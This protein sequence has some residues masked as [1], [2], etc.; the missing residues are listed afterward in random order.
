MNKLFHDVINSK[1]SISVKKCNIITL[2]KSFTLANFYDIDNTIIFPIDGKLRYGKNKKTLEKN[3]AL[4]ISSH[5]TQSISFGSTR[6]KTLAY[7]DFIDKKPKY[8]CEDLESNSNSRSEK[9]LIIS[10]DVKAYDLINIFH[11]K[12]VGLDVFNSKNILM[13]LRSISNELKNKP[14]GFNNVIDLMST[15]LVYEIIRSFLSNQPLFSGIEENY[16]YF[17]DEKILNL[18][19][20]IE[21]NINK[22]LSNKVLSNHLNISED[23]V[24]QFFRNSIGFSPQDYIEHKRMEKAIDLLRDEKNAVKVISND[25]GYKDTAYFCRRFKMMFGVQAGK[26]RKRLGEI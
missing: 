22:E 19:S 1:L 18:F 4:F 25:V 20:F 5:N 23:Y 8:I 12:Y 24:G 7:E 21:R 14:V 6:A 13:T 3:S 10:I 11:G 26:M 9:F 17:S 2:K 15:K 16:K